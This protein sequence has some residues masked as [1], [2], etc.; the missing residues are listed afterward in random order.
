MTRRY[1]KDHDLFGIEAQ[2]LVSNFDTLTES[3]VYQYLYPDDRSI[4]NVG[5]RGIYLS[6]YIRW[7]P[8]AQHDL[9]IKL[10]GYK[11]SSFSRTFDKYDYVSC[12]NYMDI[13]D[14]IKLYKHGYSKV[15][16]HAVREI[17]HKRISRQEGL[18]LV[19]QYER[20]PPQFLQLFADWLNLT[21]D[22][23]SFLLI[24]SIT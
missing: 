2:D 18:S 4:H 22:G 12:Y 10:Y 7:D 21:S 11:T 8:K 24:S 20:Q 6:N 5:V 14:L 19:R 15:T 13:H 17:R 1:R 3:D 16:D 23:M 9:M